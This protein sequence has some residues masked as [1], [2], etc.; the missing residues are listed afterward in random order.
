MLNVLDKIPLLARV[1]AEGERKDDLSDKSKERARFGASNPLRCAGVLL[2]RRGVE[3]T[4]GVDGQPL[5]KVA[6][7]T[8]YKDNETV[9]SFILYNET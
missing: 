1:E 9:D 8:K 4:D 7:D 6:K 5:M 3:V 2:K